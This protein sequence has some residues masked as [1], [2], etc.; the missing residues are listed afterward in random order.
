MVTLLR[1]TKNWGKKPLRFPSIGEWIMVIYLHNR[2]DAI[3][4]N[5]PSPNTEEFQKCY[6]EKE[7]RAGSY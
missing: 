5:Q 3:K 4:R 1:V 6:A 2:I 7:S